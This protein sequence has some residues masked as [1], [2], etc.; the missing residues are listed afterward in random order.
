[1]KRFRRHYAKAR[2]CGLV[3]T[4]V[5]CGGL[6][7]FINCL[8]ERRESQTGTHNS[9]HVLM[10]TLLLFVC[11]VVVPAAAQTLVQNDF[12]DGTSQGWIS[13]GTA[14]LANTS[15]AAHSGAHSLKTTGRTAGFNGPSLNVTTLLKSS[16]VYQVTAWVRLVAG[17][18]ADTLK[19]TVQRTVSG[20]N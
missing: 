20:A 14:V 5:P 16:T 11:S 8:P 15:E 10:A 18:P 2:V 7:M 13:R 17:Q 1:L 4:I 3:A 9:A 19:I 6:L 12:E